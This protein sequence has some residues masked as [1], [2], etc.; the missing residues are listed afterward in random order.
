MKTF[1]CNFRRATVCVSYDEWNDAEAIWI[2]SVVLDGRF[3]SIDGATALHSGSIQA[4][5]TQSVMRGLEWVGRTSARSHS[6]GAA[7]A[8]ASCAP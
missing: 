8:R 1:I 4:E 2:A 3:H 5:I 7:P 6:H